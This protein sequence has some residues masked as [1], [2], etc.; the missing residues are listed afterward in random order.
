MKRR[1]LIGL[2]V[3]GVCL[4]AGVV[5][6]R[7]GMRDPLYQ[8]KTI[9]TWA[10]QIIASDAE[11]HARSVALF[12]TMGTNAV[13]GLIRLLESRDPMWC[14]ALWRA[15]MNLSPKLRVRLL[16]HTRGAEQ[17]LDHQAA[18][19]A[20]QLIGPDAKA[21]VP[22]LARVLHGQERVARWDAA[23]ALASIGKDAV[24]ALVAALNDQDPEAR[25]AAITALLHIGPGAEAA[26]P[27]LFAR[28]Q[29]DNPGV[30]LQASEALSAIGPAAGQVLIHAIERERGIVQ[31]R[32][33]KV[34]MSMMF[35]RR[36]AEPALL[37]MASD[38]D[39]LS[40]AQAIETLAGLHLSDARVKATITA[41][42]N[43][44]AP[45]VRTAATQA[46]HD[47]GVGAASK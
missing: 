29:D 33:A 25:T 15:T 18:A 43:D 27:A 28:L 44:P 17:E 10:L 22:A 31:Q 21:A 26:I 32:A 34:L 14:K 12:R 23:Y 35:A 8:G 36:A 1:R 41:A 7:R 45:E 47:L 20:L 5:V 2:A 16:R 39:P 9:K 30:R 24:P 4:L 46:L 3:L 37:K 19:R 11:T 38:E 42:L 6:V 40:R 13:P